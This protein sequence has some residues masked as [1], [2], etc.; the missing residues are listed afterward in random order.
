[1][2]KN[3]QPVYHTVEFRG[4]RDSDYMIHLF[5]KVVPRRFH[6]TIE[7]EKNVVSFTCDEWLGYEVTQLLKDNDI[8]LLDINAE[9][10]NPD[11]LV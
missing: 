3:V 8:K 6:D 2:K 1:M 9:Y 7:V 4:K 11:D 10:G 5:M